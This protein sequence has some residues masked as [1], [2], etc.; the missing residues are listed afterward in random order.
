M[1]S[2][3]GEQKRGGG[4]KIDAYGI[5]WHDN[6]ISLTT[7]KFSNGTTRWAQA[8]SPNNIF[9]LHM[10]MNFPLFQTWTQHTLPL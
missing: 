7:M 10:C 1:Q 6:E 2:T 3:V 8:W 5:M 4:G 9:T